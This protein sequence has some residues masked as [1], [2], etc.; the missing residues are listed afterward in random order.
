M[1]YKLEKIY[2]GTNQAFVIINPAG[3]TIKYFGAFQEDMAVDEL[4]ELN[5]SLP[6]KVKPMTTLKT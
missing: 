2:S 5:A 6:V 3:E 4:E 1:K